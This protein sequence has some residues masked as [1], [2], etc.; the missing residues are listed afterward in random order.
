MRKAIFATAVVAFVALL[1]AMA[2]YWL[3]PKFVGDGLGGEAPRRGIE[4]RVERVR[5]D[6]FALSVAVDG[7]ELF[8]AAGEKLAAARFAR[9]DLA[10]SS[11]WKPRWRVQSVAVDEPQVFVRIGTKGA[12]PFPVE[13][14][15]TGETT[16]VVVDRL[17]VANGSVDVVDRSRG[18]PVE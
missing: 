13:K 9:A 1:Y 15:A 12:Q 18:S 16:A 4:L 5:T 14:A 3:A 7:P 6:P 8:G 11:L 17:Q 2:G 10:W